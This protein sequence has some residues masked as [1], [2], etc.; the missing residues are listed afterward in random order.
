MTGKTL[1]YGKVYRQHGQIYCGQ[2]VDRECQTK[3][4]QCLVRINNTNARHQHRH[5][6]FSLAELL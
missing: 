3:R 2:P 1:T 6:A 5:V 4:R